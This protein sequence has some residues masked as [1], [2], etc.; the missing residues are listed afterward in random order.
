MHRQI[1]GKLTGT[2]TKWVVLVGWI[3]LFVIATPLS[4]K[5]IDVQNNEASSWLP[6]SAESTKVVDE[7]SGTVNPNDIPTLVVYHR[8][9]GLTDADLSTMDQQAQQIAK[10]DGV[11]K[12]GV[13]SP[14]AAKALAAQGKPVP[15]LLSE[16][17]EV[18]YLYL[19]LNFGTN[20]WN[21][22]PAAADKIRD[23]ATI[24]GVEVHIAG[25]GG[26]AADSAEAF[27]GL[28]TNLLY[29]TLGVVI[30]ILLFTYRS[31][32]LWLLPIISA[33]FAYMV[34]AG[35]VYLLARY[36]DLTVNGQSQAILTIL[37]IGAGTD[38]ALLLVARFREELR[39]HD[40][41]HEAMAFALH[42]AAPAILASAATVVVGMLCL[43][44]AD[45]NS[46]AGLGPVLAV[47]V[48][49]TFLVMVTLLPALLVIFGRWM[50][51]P[52]RPMFGSSEPT[53]TG[54]WA[55]VG[56]RIRPRPR[57][58]WVVT[59]GVLAVACLGLFKLD[60]SGLTTEDSYTKEFDSI[61]GQ[62]VLTA[63]G[64]A[65]NSN[66]VQVVANTDRIN[67]VEDSIAD[68]DGLE[69]PGAVRDIGNGRSF[70]EATIAHDISSSAAF[71]TVKSARAAAH[72]VSGADA[73]VGGG[74]AF[75]LDTQTASTRDNKVIIPIVLVVVFIILVLLL[76][77]LL[78]PLLLIG[79]VVLSFGAAL[80]ISAL[81]FHY[82]FGFAGT[83]PGFPLFAFV[84]LVALGID[85]NIFLMTRVR[86]ETINHDTR[87]GSLIALSSTGGVITSAGLVL[88]ATFLVLGS[89]PLV[90]LAE[91]GIAVALG[92]LLDTMIVRSVLVTALNLDLGGKIWW[93]SKL[94][95]GAGE[96]PPPEGEHEKVGAR[97]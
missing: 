6:G 47:G 71:D 85:Y 26:Q 2:V 17:R 86:E 76:R 37:V 32:T 55:R 54:L 77:A 43:S 50:F 7:L 83:D 73:L 79:T 35:V 13:L 23:V 29:I 53:T 78:S 39:R 88:A 20:G 64:L 48:A 91:L 82:V 15:T 60:A 81:L 44:F 62:K 27:E 16:D 24:D 57:A 41:R 28:D 92:V 59:A 31:P 61:V 40:D 18:G 70:F 80:G 25:F 69:P 46:T 5:L 95:R 89:V 63:H 9:S 42:R 96:S 68:I 65:D 8:S 49:V 74:S 38:Y 22:V 21:D 67:Q 72:G 94:D 52:K 11:T 14:N 34:S 90:F 12:V 10:I 1:A 66:T 87:R 93:P 51:W 30:A 3:A 75:Y 4:A 36:A 56:E 33:M 84:F 58:V 19:T 45:L 97:V